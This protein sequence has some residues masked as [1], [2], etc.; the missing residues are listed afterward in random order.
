M[1]KFHKG[2]NSAGSIDAALSAP[3]W[4]LASPATAGV[5]SDSLIYFILP[6]TY[7]GNTN[8][9]NTTNTADLEPNGNCYVTLTNVTI[10]PYA[11][12]NEYLI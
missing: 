5:Y 7:T 8:D 2:P 4:S 1:E 9:W 12:R 10:T 6:Q 11:L 3:T